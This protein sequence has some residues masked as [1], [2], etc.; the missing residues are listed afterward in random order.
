VGIATQDP[1]LRKKFN[2][3]PEHVVN[4]FFLLAE[5]VREYM[6]QLGIRSMDELVGRAD[7]PGH[8]LTIC[9][10]PT[11]DVCPVPLCAS[12]C[13][14]ESVYRSRLLSC[15]SRVSCRVYRTDYMELTLRH[16]MRQSR[17]PMTHARRYRASQSTCIQ[18]S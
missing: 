5:E 14:V 7:F 15:L 6:A 16:A 3:K 12:R 8:P 4:F 13:A 11:W 1:E 17:T 2:G 9:R 10:V 18:L